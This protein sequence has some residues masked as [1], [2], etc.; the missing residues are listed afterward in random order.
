[1][2]IRLVV[3]ALLLALAPLATPPVHAEDR[4]APAVPAPPPNLEGGTPIPQGA[5]TISFP[6][7][8]KQSI[9]ATSDAFER[10]VAQV[11]FSDDAHPALGEVK[12]DAQGGGTGSFA[13]KVTDLVTGSKS[14]DE[15]LRSGGWLDAEK[16]PDIKLEITKLTRVKPTVFKLDGNWTMHGVTKPISTW[17]NVRY[18]PE[19]NHLGK[20][21]VRV[22]ATFDVSLKAHGL[23]N[24]G[25]G[26]DAVADAWRVDVVILGLMKKA[27]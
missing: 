25:I 18:L 4:P 2:R 14:R 15:H 27:S 20:D 1:M 3:P 19:M 6:W 13:V 12:L 22:K 26:S 23:T 7:I 21:I 8:G 10:M 9:T 5:A 16:T 17:A 24:P 11:D